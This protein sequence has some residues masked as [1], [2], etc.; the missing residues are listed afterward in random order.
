MVSYFRQ[1]FFDSLREKV[2]MSL[3][4]KIGNLSNILDEDQYQCNHLQLSSP[5]LS[6]NQ[7]KTMR[8]YMRDKVIVLDTTIELNSK[9]RTMLYVPKG[10]AH[11]FLTLSNNCE[12]IY[13]VSQEYSPKHEMGLRFDDSKIN[14]KWPKK[15]LYGSNKDMNWDLL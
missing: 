13:L 10:C 1:F 3:R 11:G 12:V 5:I 6:I 15:I 7:F 8:Q 2:V 9:N 14:I 4:T